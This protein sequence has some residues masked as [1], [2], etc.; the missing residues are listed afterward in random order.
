MTGSLHACPT[1]GNSHGLGLEICYGLFVAAQK[2]CRER[3]IDATLS[4]CTRCGYEATSVDQ[5]AAAA[6][7]PPDDFARYFTSKDAVLISIIED[8]LQASVDALGDVEPD[9]GPEHALLIAST[10][11]VSRVI[12]GRG[13]ITR[14]RM[15]AVTQVI[16]AHPNLRQQV[17]LARKRILTEA[18]A[19]RLGVAEEDRRVHQAVTRWSA[20][21]AG[22]YLV[23]GTMADH[24]DPRTDDHLIERMIAELSATFADVMGD[25][26]LQPD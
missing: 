1:C 12:D 17:S 11:V 25:N 7:V 14:D 8:V 9:T 23:G 6:D 16:T 21:A 26:P 19:D 15:L 2:D 20:I 22:A 13:V 10:E 24:Y 18:L 3:L 4:L 5:I